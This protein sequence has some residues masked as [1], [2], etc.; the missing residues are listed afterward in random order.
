MSLFGFIFLNAFFRSTEKGHR[1]VFLF[2]GF[3]D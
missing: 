3:R 1:I 2:L